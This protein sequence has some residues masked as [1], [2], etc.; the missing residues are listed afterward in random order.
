MYSTR[1]ELGI[2]NGRAPGF[3]VEF[4][5]V[6][7]DSTFKEYLLKNERPEIANSLLLDAALFKFVYGLF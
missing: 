2:A 6:E 7:R 5:M 3:E 4:L 1:V